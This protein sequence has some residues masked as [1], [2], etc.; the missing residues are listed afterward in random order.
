MIDKT[1]DL[2]NGISLL[3]FITEWTSAAFL[4]EWNIHYY[5]WMKKR[6]HFITADRL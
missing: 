2:P 6:I 1:I 4:F 3:I 5:L